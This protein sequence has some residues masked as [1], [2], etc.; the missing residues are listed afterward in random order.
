MFQMWFLPVLVG[1]KLFRFPKPGVRN[2]QRCE[3]WAK[4][5][6]PE[7]Q[8]NSIEFQMKLHN[9]YRMLCQNNFHCTD[10]TNG[11]KTRLL[12]NAVP[13]DV[14]KTFNYF[15]CSSLTISKKIS[16]GNPTKMALAKCTKYMKKICNLK[17]RIK[18]LKPRM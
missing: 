17:N 5:I 2:I 9:E 12:L 7:K 8:Y 14:S 1:V 10:F 18:N 4:D 3:L 6:A 11:S 15:P 13:S 16:K